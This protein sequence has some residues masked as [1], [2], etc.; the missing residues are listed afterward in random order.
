MTDTKRL[1]SLVRLTAAKKEA[2]LMAF[3]R[4]TANQNAVK[5]LLNNLGAV[6]QAARDAAKTAS[7][8]VIPATQT[9]F[10]RFVILERARLDAAM[11]HAAEIRKDRREAAAQSF[12]RSEVLRGLHDD[13][14][15]KRTAKQAANRCDGV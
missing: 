7:D 14:V 15:R 3:A 11:S 13:L 5:G 9:E 10:A 6:E 4:A 1:A 8:P 2:D 12:G